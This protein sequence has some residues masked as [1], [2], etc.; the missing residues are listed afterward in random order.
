MSETRPT[1]TSSKLRIYQVNVNHSIKA[2][3]DVIHLSPRDWDI[4]CIQ[5]PYFDFQGL[6]RTTNGWTAVY[7]H[8]H[9]NGVKS[10][11]I[12]LI[13]SLI[14]TDAWTALPVDSLD[15]SAVTLSGSFGRIRLFNLY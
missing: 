2:Q 5:E 1:I 7:P 14:S 10:R 4:I 9:K 12:M 13:S 15:I 11:S 6:S 8:K 3:A